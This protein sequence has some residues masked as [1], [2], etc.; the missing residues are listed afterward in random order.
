MFA[1]DL[2][3]YGTL[4]F[5]AGTTYLTGNNSAFTGVLNGPANLVLSQGQT[6]TI[7]SNSAAFNGT[8]RVVDDSILAVNGSLGGDVIVDYGT[9]KGSGN[10]NIVTVNSQGVIAP[11]NSIGTMNVGSTTF[12]PGS[13][14]EVEVNNAGQSDLIDASGTVTINGGSVKSILYPNYIPNYAYQIITAAGGVTGTFDSAMPTLFLT[15]FLSYDANNVY[16]TIAPNTDAVEN[17]ATTNNQRSVVSILDTASPNDALNALYALTTVAD[18]Q[19]ALNSLSGEAHASVT[20]GLIQDQALLRQ[21]VRIRPALQRKVGDGRVWANTFGSRRDV[22][23]SAETASMHHYT[24]GAM[25]GIDGQKDGYKLGIAVGVSDAD[26]KIKDRKSKADSESYTVML[27]GGKDLGSD[28]GLTMSAGYTHSDINTKRTIEFPGFSGTSKASYNADTLQFAAGMDKTFKRADTSMRPYVDGS[29]IYHKTQSFHESGDAGLKGD[30][31][32]NMI[33]TATLGVDVGQDVYFK[34]DMPPIHLSAGA[35]YQHVLG[36]DADPQAELAFNDSTSEYYTITGAPID[37]NSLIMRLG[38][39]YRINE[40][41]S[42]EMNY[43]AALA[44]E[45]TAHNIMG[46]ISYKF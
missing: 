26:F 7:S 12:N 17:I 22:D 14:Y 33:G 44:P 20:G 36:G 5:V 37:Q 43:G 2:V 27:Y 41:L 15:P 45:S 18:A 4:N 35:A 46:Q 39:A 24:R 16:L 31:Q 10:V 9:L 1:P 11:G 6:T 34:P 19:Q 32:V 40:T 21:Q 38:A 28:V 25:S 23:G 13:V 30:D 3:G 42:L 29:Y 8:T